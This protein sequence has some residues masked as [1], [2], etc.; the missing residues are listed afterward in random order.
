MGLLRALSLDIFFVKPIILSRSL[1]IVY[2][3]TIN[4]IS[5]NPFVSKT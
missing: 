4:S 3:L 5:P 1:Y 2:T